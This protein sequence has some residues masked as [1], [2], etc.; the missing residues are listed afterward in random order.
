MTIY[1][2]YSYSILMTWYIKIALKTLKI[3]QSMCE[4]LYPNLLV[5]WYI[6]QKSCYL[7]YFSIYS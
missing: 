3:E 2:W 6:Q 1:I 7:E 4:Y 5:Q